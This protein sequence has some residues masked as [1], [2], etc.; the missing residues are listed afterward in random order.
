MRPQRHIIKNIKNKYVRQSSRPQVKLKI[1][2]IVEN[3]QPIIKEEVINKTENNKEI[4]TE[5]MN[6]VDVNQIDTLLQ[7][8]EAK[9]PK[10]KVKVEKK[11]KGL[12]ERTENSRVILTE[13]NKMLLND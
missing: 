8:E 1:D 5:D 12:F 11:E 10:R 9:L 4:I 6:N 3:E 2:K 13:D 7:S